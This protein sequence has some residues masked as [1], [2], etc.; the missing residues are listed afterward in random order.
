MKVLFSRS[1]FDLLMKKGGCSRDMRAVL[2]LCQDKRIE[3]YICSYYLPE[4]M[5]ELE[6]D[7]FRQLLSVVS[8]LL[9]LVHV[10]A[11]DLRD[12]MHYRDMEEGICCTLA[13]R[14]KIQCVLVDKK[15][16]KVDSTIKLCTPKELRRMIEDGKTAKQR[17]N[18]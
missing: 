6:K 12:A 16:A 4:A 5:E 8:S 11:R 2:N 7:S 17:R 10:N 9:N 14:H 3:G 15:K 1:V 13:K 18:L